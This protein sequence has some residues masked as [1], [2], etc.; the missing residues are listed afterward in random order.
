MPWFIVKQPNGLYARFST[1]VDDFTVLDMTRDEA[2]EECRRE[3]GMGI[4]EAEEKVRKADAEALC[5]VT[6]GQPQGVPLSR[7]RGCLETVRRVHGPEA[8]GDRAA[9]GEAPDGQA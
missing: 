8:A 4:V 3:P 1:V 7:W 5:H 9:V 6:M 2:R